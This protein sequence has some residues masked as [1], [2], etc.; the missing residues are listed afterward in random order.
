ME[1]ITKTVAEELNSADAAER[2]F[3]LTSYAKASQKMIA[4]NDLAYQARQGYLRQIATARK[5]TPVEIQS[6]IEDGTI[7]Q[8]QELSRHYFYK[9]GYYKQ[10]ITHYATL[11]KYMGL[12]IP[13]P[14]VGQKLST[15][16]INKR[17]YGALDFV[18][19]MSLPLLLTNCAQRALVD[20]CYFG[21]RAETDKNSFAVI[22]LPT[23]YARSRFKDIEGNDLIEFDLSYFNTIVDKETKKIALNTYP[24]VIRKAYNAYAKGKRSERWFLVPS[25]I[26]ICFPFFD[27]R[28]LFLSV[29][30][31]TLE[32]DEA[33]E[34]EHERNADEIRKIIVQKIPHLTD[35]RLL[36]EPDEAA[37]IHQGTVQMMKGNSNV[38][39]LTTYGDV[40]AIVSKA[41][42]EQHTLIT[43]AEH[44]IYAQAGV[45]DQLFASNGSSTLESSIK[46]DISLMMYLAHKFERFITNLI[47]EK[48]SN[49]NISFKYVILPIS[50]HNEQKYIDSAFKLAGSG[51]SLMLP[52]VAQGFTQ[53]DFINLKDLE[54]DVLQLGEKMKPLSSAHTQSAPDA[55]NDST[56]VNNKPEA[57]EEE[58]GR[59]KKDQEEKAEGTQAKEES[60]DKTAGGS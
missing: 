1:E 52:A 3:D 53:K 41:S 9:D 57:S 47:N 20:G 54:N 36:F 22:D 39:V 49:G 27:G 10:I 37:E 50:H 31:K 43:Q 28:P 7:L 19:N 5:Y 14:K 12:L 48:F 4:T 30:P 6:I 13:N 33:I 23:G 29:I 24:K 34:L 59:P 58:G 15:S 16:H 56:D 18:E 44:N 2:N 25:D 35:G 21:V 42:N 17:Y 46:N 55:K 40:E 11:L 32:Y 45:S 26:G 8:Q 51:Y 38:S 60:L